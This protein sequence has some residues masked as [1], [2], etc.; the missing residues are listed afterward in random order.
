MNENG[1]MNVPEARVPAAAAAAASQT[2]VVSDPTEERCLQLMRDVVYKYIMTKG[3][4]PA[5]TTVPVALA[6]S[7]ADPTLRRADV[8]RLLSDHSSKASKLVTFPRFFFLSSLTGWV[9]R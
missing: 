6:L 7:T 8:L 2:L 1:N 9:C 5:Q 3:P 4:F